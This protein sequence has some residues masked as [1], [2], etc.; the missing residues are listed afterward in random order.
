MGEFREVAVSALL[1][2]GAVV[3]LL[4][5]PYLVLQGALAN[6]PA[7]GTSTHA[8]DGYLTWAAWLG[9]GL[10]LA[11]LV[12]SATTRRRGWTWFYGIA[13][14]PAAVV[15]ALAWADHV[16][17]APPPPPGPRHCVEHSGGGNECPGG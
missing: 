1:A 15:A 16:R 8:G 11:G 6:M 2:V 10:P 5:V 17:H 4:V 7:F 9:A 13:L 12:V 14:V 3:W